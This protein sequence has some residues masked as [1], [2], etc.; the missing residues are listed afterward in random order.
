MCTQGALKT[1]YH[2]TQFDKKKSEDEST[3]P[4][5]ERTTRLS[6][7]SNGKPIKFAGQSKNISNKRVEKKSL[8]GIDF[9][10]VK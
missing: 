1:P 9:F 8:A 3:C 2:T 10:S 6:Q 7:I 5:K 4:P